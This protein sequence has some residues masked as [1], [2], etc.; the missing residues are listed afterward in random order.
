M[1]VNQPRHALV[2]TA[3]LVQQPST[4]FRMQ[5]DNGELVLVER[6]GLLQDRVGHR[7]LADVVQ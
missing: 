7:Q 2:K 1:I 5:L 4:A 3:E 6:S